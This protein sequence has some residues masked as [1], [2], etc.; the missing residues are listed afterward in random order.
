MSGSFIK[1]LALTNTINNDDFLIIDTYNGTKKIKGREFIK[2]IAKNKIET[3]D[4]HI[5]LIGKKTVILNKNEEDIY[6]ATFSKCVFFDN[7]N[8]K[9]VHDK[10][11]ELNDNID[12]KSEILSNLER[13]ISFDISTLTPSFYTNLNTASGNVL[14]CLV[15]TS[16]YIFTTQVYESPEGKSESYIIS[17]LDLRGKLIDSMKI[18]YGGHG[19]SIGLEIIGEKYYIWSNYDITTPTGE[20]TSSTIAR[21]EYTPDKILEWGDII[22]EEFNAFDK[23]AI[24]TIDQNNDKIVFRIH[25]GNRQKIALYKLSEFKAKNYNEIY[26]FIIP[27]D[28]TY[29]QGMCI[30]NLDFYWRTGDTNSVRYPDEITMFDMATGNIK[31]RI[32]CTFG[33]GELGDFEG[34][35]REPEGIF[36]YKNKESNKKTLFAPVVTGGGGKRNIKV[37]MYSEVNAK[38]EF[39]SNI[40]EITQQHQLVKKG[41]LCKDLPT[42]VSKLMNITSAGTYYMT[43]TESSNFTDHP[44]PGVAG[45]IFEVGAL[46]GGVI[47]QTLKKNSFSDFII[48]TRLVRNDSTS[49]WKKLL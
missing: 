29:M 8:N 15:V 31:K 48:L 32:T 3:K 35:F 46:S 10:I 23:Y 39:E 20:K 1:D 22:I 47:Q 17:R 12:K 36:V 42:G 21:F 5:D 13:K 33:N 28:L 16:K 30:D 41:G 38:E 2:E 25:E 27:E 6:P 26:S 37:Y 14:Q 19:T 18:K 40:K 9:T 49:E 11:I 45:W 4:L 44:Y 34:D 24:P 7:K 43:T